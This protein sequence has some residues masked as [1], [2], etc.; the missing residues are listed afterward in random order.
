[1]FV[2]LSQKKKKRKKERKKEKKKENLFMNGPGR[3]NTD[4][5]THTGTDSFNGT[6]IIF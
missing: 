2:R 4:T 6:K 5:L 3:D 1:L